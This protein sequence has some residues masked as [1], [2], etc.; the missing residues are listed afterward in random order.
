MISLRVPPVATV[1]PHGL[2]GGRE[3]RG[4]TFLKVT[5]RAAALFRQTPSPLT[6]ATD[7]ATRLGLDKGRGPRFKGV[8]WCLKPVGRSTK[9]VQKNFPPVYYI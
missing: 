9:P 2:E 8:T 3:A 7:P 1:A 5:Q 4:F 6:T